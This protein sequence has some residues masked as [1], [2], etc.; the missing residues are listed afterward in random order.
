MEGRCSSM[1]L[2][3]WDAIQQTVP[4]D[5]PRGSSGDLLTKGCVHGDD[6]NG[7]CI[8]DHLIMMLMLFWV[9]SPLLS[10]GLSWCGSH[11]GESS[12]TN[13]LIATSKQSDSGLYWCQ[14]SQGESSSALHINVTGHTIIPTVPIT[15]LISASVFPCNNLC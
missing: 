1:N 12:S 15:A 8:Y 13:C 4:K 6:D 5:I 9:C 7:S 2:C 3:L 11:W 10:G 14:S